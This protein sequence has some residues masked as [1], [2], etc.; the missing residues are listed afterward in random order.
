MLAV[1]TL[2]P[3]KNLARIAA[4]VEGELR[5][6]GAR[7]WGGVEPPANV[8]WLG[9]V[10]DDELAR[11][12]PRRPLPRLR[13]ALRGLR[14]PGR[15]GARLRLPGRHERRKPDGRARRR[16]RD[17]RRPPRRRLDPRRGSRARSRRRRAASRRW[18][19]GRARRRARSTRRSR[20]RRSTPTCSAA[21]APATRPTSRTC[22]ASC[23]RVA[24]DLRFGAVTRHPELVPAG[25]EP[26]AARPR[27]SRRRGWPSRCRACCGACGPSSPTSSTR[28]RS[29]IAGRSRRHAA[30]PLLRAAD[31]RDGAPR[32]AHL[33]GRRPARRR[34]APTT[35][36]SSR[37]GPGATSSRLYGLAGGEGDRDPNGVDPSFTPGGTPRRLPPLRRRDPGPQEPARRARG[38][39]RRRA[40]ARRRRPREGPRAR[41]ARCATGAPS[42]AATSPRQ[43]LP[44]STAARRRSSSPPA[45]RASGSRC[46]RRWPAARRSSPPPSRRCARSPATPRSTP[47]AAT[48]RPP[49]G[50]RSP[51]RE[52]L[53]AAGIERAKLF[54]WEE[55]A[56]RTV[57]GLP[58]GARVKVSAIVVSHGNAARGR[59]APARARAAG[60]RAAS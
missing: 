25:V 54:S 26:I 52:R 13:V 30:R 47:R 32:P 14:D 34:A 18:A 44:S 42:S 1:G 6:V 11:A 17:L 29:G 39:A 8:A 41:R 27:A 55:T 10:D 49:P 2:E 19:R 45:S 23:R 38:R 22:C 36:S 12:L 60:R 28:S 56:R 58:A 3:R 33:P 7:G 4:A 31:T 37:S 16:R 5:V 15:R 59:G 20:D 50:G 53:S 57:D 9:E 51:T 35:C 46:S 40:A 24:P 43:E 21:S 48:S